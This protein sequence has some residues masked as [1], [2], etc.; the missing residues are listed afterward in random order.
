MQ[1]F[2]QLPNGRKIDVEAEGEDRVETLRHQILLRDDS[3]H[4]ALQRLVFEERELE[5]GRTLAEYGLCKHSELQLALRPAPSALLLNVGGHRHTTTLQTLLARQGSPLHSMFADVPQGGVP[6]FPTGGAPGPDGVME[7][8]LPGR[9]GPLPRLADG[10]YLIDRHG[11]SFE[12]ILSLLRGGASAEEVA[13]SALSS[14]DVWQL[15]VE[16]RYFGLED[17]A[18]ACRAVAPPGP[19]SSLPTLA[20]ACGPGITVAAVVALS[21]AE[22]TALLEQQKINLVMAKRL[23]YE[24]AAERVRIKAEEEAERARVAALAEAERAFETLRSGLV[25]AGA[26]D[27]SEASV[28]LLIAAGLDLRGACALDAAGARRLGLSAEE[29][30]QIGAIVQ[31]PGLGAALTFAHHVGSMQCEGS[32]CYSQVAGQYSVAVC[33]ESIDTGGG[34]VF[35]KCTVV[36]FDNW[37]TIGVISNVQPAVGAPHQDATNF[38]F[39]SN[40]CAWTAGKA[41]QAMG[42]PGLQMGDVAIMKLEAHQLSIRVQRLGQAHTVPTNGV[43]NL[44]IGVM[45]HGINRV[46]LS[47]AEV[48]EEY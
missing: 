21:D 1:L 42:V 3:A 7:A 44:R 17:L 37:L 40:G 10:A 47:Q 8:V 25:R 35:W 2:V 28:R 36:Q 48:G 29:A 4:P 46:Q 27:L 6:C 19:V 45:A 11:P 30:R 33:G 32:T 24:V 41:A 39:G 16:A 34:P 38:S 13:L 12:Y 43:Q 15:A 9:G 20:A 23:R 14:G 22:V 26:A 18:S 5:D 31:A